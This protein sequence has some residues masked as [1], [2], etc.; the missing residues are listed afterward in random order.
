MA[1]K[2]GATKAPNTCS[3]CL[4]LFSEPKVLPCCHTFCLECLKKTATS[5]T[6]EGQITCPQCRQSHEIPEGGPS[7][8]LTDFVASYELEVAEISAPKAGSG[9]VCSEC[10]QT[11]D[12]A[13]FCSDCRNYLCDEC[14]SQ[15]HKKLRI[16]R[17]HK[18]FPISE[19]D[20]AT[21]QSFRVQ[22]C[23][24]H[25]GEVL[26]L[27][28][29]TCEKVVCRDCVLV[30]HRLHS[31][32]FVQVA[33]KQI[34][35]EIR[36]LK[37]DVE[38]K[39]DIF[40]H[41]LCEIS[42][43]DTAVAGYPQ[44][45][46]ANINSFFDDVIQS[47]EAR[48]GALLLEA[49]T[50][51]EM[52]QKQIW[53]DKSFH[54]TAIA[55]ISAVFSHLDK[56]CR[57]TND[58]EMIL[59]ALQGISQLRMIKE[60]E[61]NR[62]ALTNVLSS[63][64]TFDAIAVD[65]IGSIINIS[66]K[67]NKMQIVDFRECAQLRRSY[68]INVVCYPVES[69]VDGRSNKEVFLKAQ[70]V[71]TFDLQVKVQYG[72]AKRVLYSSCI[73][74]REIESLSVSSESLSE[75]SMD[76]TE[77]EVSI[78][79]VCGGPHLVT[80]KYEDGKLTHTFTVKGVP[81]SGAKVCEGPDWGESAKERSMQSHRKSLESQNDSGFTGTVSY[82]G[83]RTPDKDFAMIPVKPLTMIPTTAREYKWGIDSEYEIELA[84]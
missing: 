3:V 51:C 37:S 64:P 31:Y 8:L 22:Y 5:G 80:L 53:A 76:S 43:V 75:S 15:L 11:G 41:D 19:V 33:R 25:E 6:T 82:S 52:D 79:P 57:C 27:Y 60:R 61:W 23:S 65:T 30:D 36:S 55:H 32:K 44:V 9:L 50:V 77:Y 7:E 10:G 72:R 4:E 47:I 73:T 74:I 83:K 81:R 34:E 13:H 40:K 71:K 58:S 20:A 38:K 1:A 16:Y 26:K 56:A 18:V 45:L 46:K 21:L 54:E 59:T 69:V 78:R 48:R 66:T 39:L 17:G 12:L 68:S 14:A 42:E 84:L 67:S 24:L 49:E 62:T 29:E 28:W 2:R 35:A 70:A 63:T